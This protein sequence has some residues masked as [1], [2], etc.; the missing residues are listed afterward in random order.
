MRLDP[1]DIDAIAQR[2][3]ALMRDDAPAAAARLVD[4]AELAS[5]L[6]VDRGW[7]YAHAKELK[8][9]RLG[10]PRGRFRFDVD[11]VLRAMNGGPVVPRR[12]AAKRA[13]KLVYLGGELLPIDP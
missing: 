13:T 3:V 2:V 8:G 6:G 9:V 10:G 1:A 7:V 12:S 4:A 11:A 5:T